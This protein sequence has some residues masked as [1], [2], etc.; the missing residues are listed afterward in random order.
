MNNLK[1]I[2]LT[3]LGVVFLLA[4]QSVSA[5]HIQETTSD[6]HLRYGNYG[7][8][9]V[10]V[11]V[12]VDMNDGNY[13]DAI[14]AMATRFG[15]ELLPCSIQFY[16]QSDLQQFCDDLKSIRNKYN[17]WLNLSR[18]NGVRDLVKDVPIKTEQVELTLYDGNMNEL[19]TLTTPLK[20]VF[21]A[22]SGSLSL[23]PDGDSIRIGFSS[24]EGESVPIFHVRSV[25]DLDKILNALNFS[26]IKTKLDAKIQKSN[27]FN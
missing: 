6:F 25:A 16:G 7:D 27:L 3:I 5:Q 13:A 24:V 9:T 19:K 15:G 26:K 14:Y 22:E 2:V 12:L 10:R 21:R 17:E 18:Q 23:F 20:G 1:N 4:N 11:C 8:E